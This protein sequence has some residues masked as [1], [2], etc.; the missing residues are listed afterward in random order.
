MRTETGTMEISIGSK[1]FETTYQKKIYETLEDVLNEA[2]SD[3]DKG[4]ALVLKKINWA[5]DWERKTSARQEFI[6]EGDAAIADSFEKQVKMYM[7]NR[8]KAGKP[9][10]EAQARAKVQAM[11]DED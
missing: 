5:E 6:K 1:K 11:I 3:G 8:E 9:V 10:T 2:S 4:V 7:K